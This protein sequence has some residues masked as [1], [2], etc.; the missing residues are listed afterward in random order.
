MRIPVPMSGWSVRRRLN[1]PAFKHI[2]Q[3]A[4]RLAALGTSAYPPEIRRR[5][6]ILNLIAYLIAGSTLVYAIQYAWRDF[7]TYRPII[8]L[9]LALVLMA[10]LVPLSHRTSEIAGGLLIV[11]TEYMAL[12]AFT[13]YLGRPSGIHLQ[14]FV[15]AA[16]PFVVFGLE[17]IRLVLVIVVSGTI[18]HLIAWFHFPSSKALID[19]DAAV[20]DSLY[21]H[22]A[23][24]TAGLI[25]ASV[26]Y[27]FRLVEQARAETDALLHNI[28]PDSVADRLKARPGEIIAD[29]HDEVSVLFA[30]ISGFVALARKLGAV[31]V[32]QLLNRIVSAFDGLAAVH[33]VE[34]IKTIGDA[35]MAVA[36][37]PEAVPDHTERLVRLGLD[38]LAVVKGLRD[39]T[40]LEL[41]LRIGI[42]SGPVMAGVI[43]T[44]KFSYD[45]WGDAVNLAARL[46]GWSA[47]GRILICPNCQA[48]L[49]RTMELEPRGRID[50][51]GVGLQE[52]WF[53]ART[54]AA[55]GFAPPVSG[56]TGS[57]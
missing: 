48:R 13:A 3:C 17:R 57:A 33:G 6:K 55:P 47:P 41:H 19:A 16:A 4:Y 21:T 12:M 10:I 35:Y 40:G 54:Q 56:R 38:M 29:S 26:W 28:L 8:Y 15:A 23:I 7:D 42:A 32:V 1:R 45:V 22:A 25:A 20:L 14:Y 49:A 31:G 9:N 2:A 27:A 46:E 44:R 39:E 11:V 53:I 52:A 18:L 5:L 37:L 43:G 30:D 51:K 34:K 36:G 24:T 50:I